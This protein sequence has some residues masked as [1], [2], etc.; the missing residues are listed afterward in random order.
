M[1]KKEK[2]VKEKPSY[3]I[4]PG[5]MIKIL[6]GSV[7]EFK[8]D[9]IL[10]PVLVSFEVLLDVLI[11]YLM[12]YLIDEGIK[13][14]SM[15]NILLYGGLLVCAAILA[16]IF[17]ALAGKYAA[18]A[19][20][21]FASNLRKDM[22]YNIQTFSF[23]NIDKFSTA[24]LIT[25]MTKDV[26]SIQDTYQIIIR[27]A[28]RSPIM[29]I[30]ATIMAFTVNPQVS[31]IFLACLPVMFI[32]LLL[33]M[34]VAHPLFEKMFT[35]FDTLNNVVE[36][37]LLGMRVVKAYVREDHETQKFNKISTAIYKLGAKAEKIMAC[38]NPI[39]MA[40]VYGCMLFING[41]A[42]KIIVESGGTA[43]TTGQLTSLIS[44]VMQIMMSLMMISMCIV[45][46]TISRAAGE[47]VSEVLIEK[48]TIT[49]PENPV[50]EI[51][52]G[53]IDFNDVSFRYSQKAERNAL[54]NVNLHIKS[55][56]TVGIIGGTGSSKTT[57]VQLIPR[58]YD[59][60]E[61][62]VMVGGMNVQGYDIKTLRDGVA[63]VLQKNELFSGTIKENLRWGNEDAT[64][65]QIIEACKIAQADDFI[66]TFPDG[67]DS[68]I[69]Q[70]GTNVSGGQKQRLCIA[71][72]LL[73]NPK[74]L[75]LDDSTSAVDTRT[76]A[77]IRESFKSYIPGTTKIIIAQRVSSVQDADKIIVMDGGKIDGI[78]TH[79]ELIEN[80]EIYREVYESQVKGGE[81]ND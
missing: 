68:R 20:A 56:E 44:Y 62:S 78:G 11:P 41:Y 47:R 40:C 32:G 42:A 50:M 1:T 76:D 80:N 61:G 72:A 58:L 53:S 37:N 60:S 22:Y 57:L 23:A 70:G 4:K 13:K 77:C 69:E 51:R 55:G 6:L 12:S 15:N 31:L 59:T 25:R 46:I 52:D 27:T 2:T 73:K 71:R 8:R 66:Q 35:Q 48:A 65:E 10:S 7:K 3:S 29:F 21:G 63:M 34:K 5:K 28:V 17:G 54:E 81:D 79:E 18:R 19:S 43:M 67:Y 39:M 74:I 26:V 9:S 24:S 36:E 45:F 49:N 30:F 16:L 14:S 64:D 38:T 75:I 33:V